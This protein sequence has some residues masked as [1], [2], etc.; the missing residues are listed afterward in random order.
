MEIF[1]RQNNE[2]CPKQKILIKKI[3][4]DKPSLSS[5][6]KH[7]SRKKKCLYITFR[8]GRRSY[9]E[10]KHKIYK[11]NLT[12]I[13]RICGKNY[14]FDLLNRYSMNTTETCKILSS[15]TNSKN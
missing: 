8:I 7:A 15:F 11:N 12:P 14:F 4:K 1:Q 5:C 13:V 9:I 3:K 10:Q 2:N 6:M